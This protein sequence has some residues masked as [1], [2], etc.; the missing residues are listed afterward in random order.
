MITMTMRGHPFDM[1]KLLAQ[2]SKKVAL[3]N[4]N[5]NARGDIVTKDGAIKIPREQIARQY[6]RANPK[7]VKQIPLRSINNEV[8]TTYDTPA[9][10]VAKQIELIAAQREA[11]KSKRRIAD[12]EWSSNF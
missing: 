4:A 6:H 9:Q 3:G 5:M 8:M 2:N 11:A 7:A 10:A 12:S 1:N